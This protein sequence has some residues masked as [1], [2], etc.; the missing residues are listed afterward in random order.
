MNQRAKE[1]TGSDQ[2][3]PAITIDP[4]YQGISQ[5]T[6]QWVDELVATQQRLVETDLEHLREL[7]VLNRMAESLATHRSVDQVLQHAADEAAN[8]TRS[9]QVYVAEVRVTGGIEQV[10]MPAGRRVPVGKLP[11]EVGDL[12]ERMAD[13]RLTEPSMMPFYDPAQGDRSIFVGLP[14]RTD[15]HIIGGLVFLCDDTEKLETEHQLRLLTSM[16]NQ[17]AMAC[18]NSVLLQT[19]SD[20]VVDVVVAMAQAIES[21][22]EYTGGHV[23][24]VTGYAVLLGSKRGLSERD[25]L[26]LRLGGLLHDI[27][28][29]AVPDAILNKPAKLTDQEFEIIKSHA[30]VGAHIVERIPQLSYLKDI[31]RH[32]HERFDGRGYP[33]RLEGMDIPLLARIMAVADTYDAMTSDRPYRKGLAHEV[34]IEEIK[35][36]AG[37]QFDPEL[38]EL[39]VTCTPDQLERSA[40]EA[41]GWSTEPLRADAVHLLDL[42]QLPMAAG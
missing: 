30:A 17:V 12:I 28:K 10:V 22:D 20:M 29:V 2:D 26:L 3:D 38:A 16:L 27:G 35:K 19:I 18:E 5:M 13:E 1:A 15:Q 24:R 40:D 11:S 41:R 7:A 14:I 6:Q 36:C 32:H 42:I 33:D 23:H 37:G 25:L 39:F 31:V 8:I 34:A 21:R 9:Q 4:V